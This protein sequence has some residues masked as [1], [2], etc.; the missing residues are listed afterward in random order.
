MIAAGGTSQSL[1]NGLFV[2]IV[3]QRESILA[4]YVNFATRFLGG[5]ADDNDLAA[6][7]NLAQI[8]FAAEVSG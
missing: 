7:S 4:D 8:L 3:L 5:R 1:G 2:V 6:N